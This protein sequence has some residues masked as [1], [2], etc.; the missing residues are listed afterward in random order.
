MNNQEF[1]ANMDYFLL[2]FFWSIMKV[3]NFLFFILLHLISSFSHTRSLLIP[4]AYMCIESID[5][6][7]LSSLALNEILL[8]SSGKALYFSLLN[9]CCDF[10][11]NVLFF[12]NLLWFFLRLSTSD[13]FF[14]SWFI[15]FLTWVASKNCL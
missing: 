2:C 13:F 11:I 1:V 12:I 5:Y 9:F 8:T 6:T 10:N 3:N 7:F 4:Y 15:L 14:S